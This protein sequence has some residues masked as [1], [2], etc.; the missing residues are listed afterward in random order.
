MVTYYLVIS[1]RLNIL[2]ESLSI[3]YLSFD[4]NKQ[5]KYVIFLIE[6]II[7]LIYLI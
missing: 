4:R 1:K 3:F 5:T 6:S 7:I 2:N